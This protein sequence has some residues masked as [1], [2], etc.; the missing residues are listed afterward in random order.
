MPDSKRKLASYTSHRKS[1]DDDDQEDEEP[2][3]LPNALLIGVVVGIVCVLLN[4]AITFI[5][6]PISQSVASE[7]KAVTGNTYALIG[8]GCASFFIQLIACFI[9]GF[10]VGK[11][12][13]QRQPGFYAGILVAA[14]SYLAS[15]VV[16]YIPN[17]PG[18]M[19]SNT[20]VNGAAVGG[21]IAT[22]IV[23]L[24]IW[25]LIG[26]LIGLWGARVATR[27]HPVYVSEEDE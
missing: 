9:A 4:V 18:N 16:R 15:F 1:S 22:I 20:P 8:L 24:I 2:S 12:V 19:T 17:Y 27:N 21:G 23:F 25:S 26:G 13:A 10:I 7:G 6:A 3:R 5:G 14:I 11:N